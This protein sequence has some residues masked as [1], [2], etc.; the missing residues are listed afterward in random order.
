MSN[1]WKMVSKGV[2]EHEDLGVIRQMSSHRWVYENRLGEQAGVE[3]TLSKAKEFAG[4]CLP[5][6]TATVQP[7]TLAVRQPLE[8]RRVK[9]KTWGW[10]AGDRRVYQR[11]VCRL[12]DGTYVM[13]S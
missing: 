5:E 9:H 12:S 2:Y 3:R 7:V 10:F 6:R 13:V 8:R 1:G 4:R 11:D